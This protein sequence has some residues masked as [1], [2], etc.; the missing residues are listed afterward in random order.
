MS[1][2]VLMI[3]STASVGAASVAERIGVFIETLACDFKP[4]SSARA[5]P[6][7]SST[8]A[9]TEPAAAS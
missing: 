5:L 4:R 2:S 9:D 1:L 3:A 7:Q 6:A 8:S